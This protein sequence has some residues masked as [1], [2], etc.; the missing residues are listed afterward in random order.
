MNELT[1]QQ[2]KTKSATEVVLKALNGLSLCEAKHVLEMAGN[3]LDT[4]AIVRYP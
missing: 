1:D 3:S 4:K 2:R